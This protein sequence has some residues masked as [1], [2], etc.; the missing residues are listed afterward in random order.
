MS[1]RKTFFLGLCSIFFL[2]LGLLVF[3]GTSFVR[4]SFRD[5]AVLGRLVADRVYS[6]L[7]RQTSQAQKQLPYLVAREGRPLSEN[8]RIL[9]LLDGDSSGYTYR[10]DLPV[11]VAL[12]YVGQLWE[13]RRFF[14]AD[15]EDFLLVRRFP[16]AG[17]D[18]LIALL[19]EF[20][21]AIPGDLADEGF[22]LVLCD[23]SGRILWQDGESPFADRGHVPT[24]FLSSV[25]GWHRAPWG[26]FVWGRSFS[27]SLGGLRLFVSYP[28]E[29][30][31]PAIAGKLLLPGGLAF[32]VFFLLLLLWTFIR[33]RIL[34]P[35]DRARLAALFVG[36]SLGENKQTETAPQIHALGESMQ[37][38]SERSGLS[39]IRDF[40][41]AFSRS[42]ETI[43]R[44][45]EELLFYTEA[46]GSMNQVLDE[47]NQQILRRDFVWKQT[48][49]TSQAIARDGVR[50][51]LLEHLCDIILDSSGAFGI[52][53]GQVRDGVVE[54]ILFRG[55]DKS[56]FSEFVVPVE[57]SLIGQ[58]IRE[59]R[60]VW[61][62][63]PCNS[64]AYYP[65][66]PRVQ[67][68]V[69]IPLY[70]LGKAV[71]GMT[72]CWDE[73]REEDP[74]ILDTVLPLAAYVAGT[75]DAEKS[76]KD[77]RASYHYLVNRLQH[78][79]AIYHEETAAHLTRTERYCRFLA[80]NLGYSGDEVEDIGFFSRLHD[81]GKLRIPH[82]I[83]AKSGPLTAAEFDVVKQHSAW[84]ADILGE[85]AWLAM[86]RRICLSHHEKW[87]GSGYP[88]GLSGEDIPREARIM[89]LADVYDALR[90]PRCYKAAR[91]HD[92][93]VRV[94]LEGDGRVLPGHFD[95]RLLEIFRRDHGKMAL[96]YEEFSEGDTLVNAEGIG[97]GV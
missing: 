40:G 79:T 97:L 50:E 93:A 61:V 1:L 86:G 18:Y 71:G 88:H 90:S 32:A 23:S 55:F 49:E 46:L 72:L 26:G 64:G 59:E 94:I 56:A 14:G 13:P 39:E 2:L 92:E 31:L 51:D 16:W 19:P 80:E 29:T 7:V 60:P 8:V 45:E 62:C 73:R 67:T 91:S 28:L 11:G 10:G 37:T 36:T 58:A 5:R 24:Y 83:L 57:G 75:V 47:T 35:V 84:G 17:R 65:L 44:K 74:A 3:M 77:L 70:H 69:N 42:L 95:P 48:L 34:D 78:V 81:I 38:L 30:L 66:S 54:P 21:G 76:K 68:E 15:D 85:A 41:Q 12:G 27:L 87:D 89:A 43:A 82:D 22:G 33:H 25:P 4:E 9:A 96:I 52:A 6:N 53:L 20:D 63:C